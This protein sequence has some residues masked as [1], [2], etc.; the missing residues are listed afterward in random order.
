MGDDKV[1][2]YEIMFAVYGSEDGAAGAVEALKE[3][4]KAKSIKI[5]DAATIVKDTEGNT[6]VTQASVPQVKKGPKH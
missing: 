3:M 6:H 4:D 1:Q 5:V 2:N